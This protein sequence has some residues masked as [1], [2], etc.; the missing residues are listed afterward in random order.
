MDAWWLHTPLA[1][2]RRWKSGRPTA[3]PWRQEVIA[4]L[5][6]LLNNADLRPSFEDVFAVLQELNLACFSVCPG[7]R[8]LQQAI[9]AALDQ[10]D[11]HSTQA[12]DTALKLKLHAY[13]CPGDFER[14]MQ[15]LVRAIWNEPHTSANHWL[16]PLDGSG[17]AVAEDRDFCQLHGLWPPQLLNK[18]QQTKPS[19]APPSRQTTLNH[20][21][22][23]HRLS[24][25]RIF[26]AVMGELRDY[27]HHPTSDQHSGD[28]EEI[29]DRCGLS[30]G[31]RRLMIAGGDLR[32]IQKH[33]L[34]SC[35]YQLGAEVPTM[36]RPRKLQLLA[37]PYGTAIR[38]C[39]PDGLTMKGSMRSGGMTA[40]YEHWPC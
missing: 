3:W 30:R 31:E 10:L 37:N 32:R 26:R 9:D 24:D 28:L 38:V 5:H 39:N 16:A 12:A 4:E 13:S 25:A 8:A 1:T 22:R 19:K 23:W 6:A 20:R 35:I 15:G 17:F 21:G 34:W 27:L 7:G 36:R 18:G 11:A 2:C 14:L 40:R 33:I 29:I